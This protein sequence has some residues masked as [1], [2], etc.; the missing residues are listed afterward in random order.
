MG[1]QYG[2]GKRTDDATGINEAVRD[3]Y[4][5]GR[6]KFWGKHL[7]MAKDW[8]TSNLPNRRAVA[9]RARKWIE[10]YMGMINTVAAKH[11]DLK[12]IDASAKPKESAVEMFA[13][14][15]KNL[16]KGKIAGDLKNFRGSEQT[17][18]AFSVIEEH[19]TQV[20]Q[21]LAYWLTVS[22]DAL[23]VRER[24]GKLGGYRDSRAEA[25]YQ[26]GRVAA[27]CRDHL[28]Q[29]GA[30]DKYMTKELKTFIA[31]HSQGKKMR[32]PGKTKIR[33]ALVQ[34]KKLFE[35]CW[36]AK[37]GLAT[38]K[39]EE[40]QTPESDGQELSND[41]F[42]EANDEQPVE[43]VSVPDVTAVQPITQMH[44]P[45]QHVAYQPPQG[46]SNGLKIAILLFVVLLVCAALA[47]MYL[48]LNQDEDISTRNSF[49]DLEAG[50]GRS[51]LNFAKQSRKADAPE[52][53]SGKELESAGRRRRT[54]RRRTKHKR[55]ASRA[56]PER[57]SRRHRKRSRAPR[58][59]VH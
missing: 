31:K 24:F 57:K 17:N 7:G 29:N 59:R 16:L 19:Y 33:K 51:N 5:H 52:Y 47:G 25:S 14:W 32:N 27:L 46:M 40:E 45:Q 4:N 20:G 56:R 49:V 30:Y 6:R 11:K 21:L 37:L 10:A 36:L 53:L 34:V 48:Y 3:R 35:D 9:V 15:G 12:R 39:K 43:T 50:L 55:S 23:L 41:L 38:E 2:D 22:I 42:V 13:S 58:V 18:S 8:I 1:E 26:V 44:Q 28:D 54:R